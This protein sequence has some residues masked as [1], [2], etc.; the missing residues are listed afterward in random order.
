MNDSLCHDIRF[1]HP[2]AHMHC[3]ACGD[4]LPAEGGGGDDG[5]KVAGYDGHACARCGDTFFLLC[6]ACYAKNPNCPDC[7]MA[8]A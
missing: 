3:C 1:C 8:V 7:Q 4:V 5:S 6:A 2:F